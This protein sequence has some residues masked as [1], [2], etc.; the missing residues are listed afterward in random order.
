MKAFAALLALALLSGPAHAEA[1]PPLALEAR[2]PLGQVK[3]RLDHLAID[4][5]R[6]RLFVAELGA[7]S[8]GVVDLKAAK[9]L[10]PITGQHEPQGLGY[11]P[12]TDT[13][14]VAS[15]GDGQVRLY[16]GADLAPAGSVQVGEDADNVRVDPRSGEL[17]VGYGS[18]AIAWVDPKAVRVVGQARLKGHPES[19]RLDP[20]GGRIFVNVP[21]AGQVAVLDAARRVQV[22]AWPVR[23][24]LSNFPMVIDG[25]GRVLIVTRLPGLLRALDPRDGRVLAEAHACGDSDDLFFDA[26]R[27]RIYVSC[28]DGHIDVFADRGAG[29]ERLAPIPTSGGARTSLWVPELDRLFLAVRAAG[30][31]PAAIWAYR[32][33]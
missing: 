14:Y 15:G 26:R 18:G 4:L 10:A 6:R 28:G 11:L 21:N 16:R 33:Q 23:S 8:V 3:G 29:F 24:A 31:Q 17:L 12:S 25:G 19:F 7:D 32:P 20:S 9:A 22:A 27:G 2:I 30:D 5:A 1:P 13:L